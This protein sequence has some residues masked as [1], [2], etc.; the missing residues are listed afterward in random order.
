MDYIERVAN[1]VS[2]SGMHMWDSFT[3]II[4]GG[5]HAY[6][7]ATK[8][9]IQY[10]LVSSI[11]LGG[12]I[13]TLIAIGLMKIAG[14]YEENRFWR[15]FKIF[16][17]F[18]LFVYAGMQIN[19]GGEFSGFPYLQSLTDYWDGFISD[20]LK[21]KILYIPMILILLFS[22]GYPEDEEIPGYVRVGLFF[23]LYLSAQL[24]FGGH[25]RFF[26]SIAVFLWIEAMLIQGRA[27][28]NVAHMDRWRN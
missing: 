4:M 11:F 1:L 19:D 3:A 18:N 13:F 9:S 12:L 21:Y 8:A 15:A 16:I 10:A 5:F 26:I 27:I 6:G 7:F 14:H 17:Y 22:A 28:N 2:E 20:F 25:S 24:W 23:V